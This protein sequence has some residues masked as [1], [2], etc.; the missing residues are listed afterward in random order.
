MIHWLVMPKLRFLQEQ[1]RQ[2]IESSLGQANDLQ[3]RAD[4]L[5]QKVQ[6]ALDQARL[7]AKKIVQDA[8]ATSQE[9]LEHASQVHKDVYRGH[10][11]SL[12]DTIAAERG[13]AWN[14]LQE[15]IPYLSQCLVEKWS[16][17]QSSDTQW[18]D[19][20]DTSIARRES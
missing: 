18:S 2:R 5:E 16:D 14:T 20:G 10:L 19:D 9:R 17:A 15:T 1:R 4:Q 11:A 12:Q 7:D 13:H 3:A 6:Q 8:I